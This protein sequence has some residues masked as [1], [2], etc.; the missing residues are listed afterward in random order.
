MT[1]EEVLDRQREGLPTVLRALRADAY[2]LIL[3]VHHGMQQMLALGRLSEP[4]LDVLTRLWR[5][6]HIQAPSA[7]P[8]PARLRL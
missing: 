2:R 3:T 1:A 4:P 6:A 8:W 7:E 5:T